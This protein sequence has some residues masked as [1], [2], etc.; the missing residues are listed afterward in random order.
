MT[1][2]AMLG[3]YPEVVTSDPELV[4]DTTQGLMSE[5]RMLLGR[6]TRTMHATIRSVPLQRTGLMF[7]EYG[8]E[9]EIFSPLIQ[10]YSTVHLPLAGSIDVE[11]NGARYRAGP[12]AGLVFSSERP[13]HMRWNADLR[14]MVMRFDHAALVRRLQSLLGD[15]VRGPLVFDTVLA[16]LD[17]ADSTAGLILAI[18]RMLADR[19][20][21]SPIVVR[22]L[23]EA[24][25]SSLLLTHAHSYRYRLAEP[26]RL[27]SPRTVR[28]AVSEIESRFD[29]ELTAAS[30][31]S[32]AGVSERTLQ[33]AFRRRFGTTAVQYLRNHRFTVAR[34]RLTAGAAPTVAAI[35]HGVGIQHLGRFAAEY[36]RR[37]GEQ[38]A[39]TLRRALGNDPS[40][41]NSTT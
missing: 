30:L 10:G 38:P 20:A 40:A 11:V 29:E 35:A 19:G 27:P 31:A 25:M 37:Y 24:R 1:G 26:V 6:S 7:F 12:G 13:V 16:N 17:G 22:A 36:R 32:S 34:E 9:T 8:T 14:L 18:E 15:D 5:H 23:E 21:L 39:E 3:G 41:S 28:I 4:H 33:A 2:R